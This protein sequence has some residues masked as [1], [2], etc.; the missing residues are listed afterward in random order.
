MAHHQLHIDYDP[1]IDLLLARFGVPAEADTVVID[2][3]IAVRLSR[4]T[5]QPIGL[6]IVD[7]GARFQRTITPAFVR[8]LLARYGHEASVLLE[9]RRHTPVI[10]EPLQHTR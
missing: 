6:E 4:E 8:E 7:C 3:D 1:D 2:G 5:R 10:A 9:A